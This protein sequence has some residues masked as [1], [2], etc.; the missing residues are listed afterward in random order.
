[1]SADYMHFGIDFLRAGSLLVTRGDASLSPSFHRSVMLIT[2]QKSNWFHGIFLHQPVT[3]YESQNERQ[4]AVDFLAGHEYIDDAS[5][6]ELP[7]L[8]GSPLNISNFSHPGWGN[9]PREGSSLSMPITMIHTNMDHD[10]STLF[11]NFAIARGEAACKSLRGHNKTVIFQHNYKSGHAL[12]KEWAEVWAG[13][14]PATKDVVID[15]PPEER[16]Q[17]AMTQLCTLNGY[18]PPEFD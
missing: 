12:R 11:G 3:E 1:M 8:N 14:I 9:V 2:N 6:I 18:T 7:I 16:W 17:Q 5:E 13:C 15:T 4:E 10:Q